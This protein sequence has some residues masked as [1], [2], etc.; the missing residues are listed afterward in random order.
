MWQKLR[1]LHELGLTPWYTGAAPAPG[2]TPDPEPVVDCVLSDWFDTTACTEPCGGGTKDQ[3]RAV[4]TNPSNGGEACPALTQ[5]VACNEQSCPTPGPEPEPAPMP[6]PGTTSC[7]VRVYLGNTWSCGG[8]DKCADVNLWFK[9]LGPSH[10]SA[11]W[12]FN[13]VNPG[14]MSSDSQWNFKLLSIS[15]GIVTGQATSGWQ[16]LQKNGGNEINVGFI[17]KSSGTT[18]PTQVYLSGN[19]CALA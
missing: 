17:V 12:T 19:Q 8:A 2:P 16:Q 1:Y 4:V 9:N 7:V 11:P 5:T 6:N 13:V 14:Y 3:A 15:G 10:V 18:P